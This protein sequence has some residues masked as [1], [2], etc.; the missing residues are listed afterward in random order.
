MKYLVIGLVGWSLA[1]CQ[2]INASDQ[3]AV[4]HVESAS[5]EYEYSKAHSVIVKPNQKMT[6]DEFA[7][8][9]R[10]VDENAKLISE[11]SGGTFLVGYSKTDL[12]SFL[13]K[14]NGLEHIN[15]ASPNQKKR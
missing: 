7:A 14:L 8:L 13:K 10:E 12:E 5:Q 15:Y 11:G 2:S 9:L 4:E 1:A 6:V 3:V